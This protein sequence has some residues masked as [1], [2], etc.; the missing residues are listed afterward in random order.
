MPAKATS[1]ATA[2][3]I[4][5]PFSE[6]GLSNAT[7]RRTPE[8]RYRQTATIEQR[9]RL[10]LE[11]VTMLPETW[12]LEEASVFYFWVSLSGRRT[13][14][15]IRVVAGGISPCPDDIIKLVLRSCA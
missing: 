6:G 3:K 7:T 5:F 4:H 12:A 9:I 15:D 13:G 2:F 14:A 11:F 1:R 10:P 8:M